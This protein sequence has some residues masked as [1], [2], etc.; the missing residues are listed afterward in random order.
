MIPKTLWFS[1]DPENRLFSTRYANPRHS[2]PCLIM[3]S[4]GYFYASECHVFIDAA[5]QKL[6]C[7]AFQDE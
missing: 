6:A 1:A 3:S 7:M 4:V 5:C 2:T